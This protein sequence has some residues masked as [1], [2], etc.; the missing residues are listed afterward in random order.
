MQGAEQSSKRQTVA[1][2]S[3]KSPKGNDRRDEESANNRKSANN[4]MTN[5]FPITQGRVGGNLRSVLVNTCCN[6]VVVKQSLVCDDEL[7]GKVGKLTLL[8]RSV[9]EGVAHITI[10]TPL[11]E[12]RVKALCIDNPM[13]N[14]E[15]LF[16]GCVLVYS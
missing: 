10:Y 7:M 13:L 8:D 3:V 1:S 6:E 11:Y 12:G 15:L 16:C 9:T 4:L 5:D 2:G 14:C